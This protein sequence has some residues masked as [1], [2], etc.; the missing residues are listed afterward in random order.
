V[1]VVVVVS[2][3]TSI[4]EAMGAVGIGA[5]VLGGGDREGELGLRPGAG[6]EERLEGLTGRGW[7]WWRRLLRRRPRAGPVSSLV[8]WGPAG[9][10]REGRKD[11]DKARRGLNVEFRH[12][13][14]K[15]T[16]LI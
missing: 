5:G 6:K 15:R 2:S 13:I 11:G 14:I 4:S 1:A 12:Q 3:S 10:E 9:G 16:G 8:G 7:R